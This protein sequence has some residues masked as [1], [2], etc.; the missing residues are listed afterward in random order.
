MLDS[1]CCVVFVGSCV[2]GSVCWVVF[3]GQCVLARVG[4]VVGAGQWV[5]V[6]SCGGGLAGWFWLSV[7]PI[8][9][10]AWATVYGTE[11]GGS[12]AA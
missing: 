5:L 4:W 9:V 6:S 8:P 3:V 11:R 10:S 1:V 12:R 7:A 2:L